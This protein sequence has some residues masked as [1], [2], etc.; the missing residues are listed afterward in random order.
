[1]IIGQEIKRMRKKVNM[2]QT[3][4]ANVI[5]VT[6]THMSQLENSENH[7]SWGLIQKIL[8]VTDTECVFMNAN[9][10]KLIDKFIPLLETFKKRS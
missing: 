8:S 2:N 9:D 3:Q 7:P 6:Q 4:L 1:M 10:V 5:G